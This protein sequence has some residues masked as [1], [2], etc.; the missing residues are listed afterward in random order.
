MTDSTIDTAPEPIIVSD[1]DIE[2]IQ[3]N[4]VLLDAQLTD[5][6]ATETNK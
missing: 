1:V 6:I 4:T 2:A 5:S 3:L